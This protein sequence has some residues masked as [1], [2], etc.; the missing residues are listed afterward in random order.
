MQTWNS[1]DPTTQ[2]ALIGL[3]VSALVYLG[4]HLVPAWFASNTNVA[5]FTRTAT[6]VL[7]AGVAVLGKTL[8]GGWTGVVPFLLA[9]AVAYASAE[10]AHTLVSRT[11]AL[12]DEPE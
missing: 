3:L 7:L 8:A 12:T 10:S 9:W 1:L 5:V 4:R 6:V 11:N 2:A